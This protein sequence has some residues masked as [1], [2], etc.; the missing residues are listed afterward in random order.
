ML[1]NHF[2][3]VSKMVQ[4]GSLARL[5]LVHNSLQRRVEGLLLVRVVPIHGVVEELALCDDLLLCGLVLRPATTVFTTSL[6]AALGFLV[7][8]YDVRV[9]VRPTDDIGRDVLHGHVLMRLMH[10]SWLDPLAIARLWNHLTVVMSG[11]PSCRVDVILLV[12]NTWLPLVVLLLLLLGHVLL[13]L[14]LGWWETC[15]LM[16]LLLLLWMVMGHPGGH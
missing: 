1:G 2:D 7:M 15:L 16:L 11:S 12:V 5:R 14:L 10:H 3:F 9:D 13:L 6:A 8:H 4:V